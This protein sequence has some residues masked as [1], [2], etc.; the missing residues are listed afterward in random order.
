MIL[1]KTNLAD[2][3]RLVTLALRGDHIKD[4]NVIYTKA[5]YVKVT[6]EDDVLI[7]LDGELGGKT[8]VELKT[9]IDILIFLLQLTSC[10]KRI[11]LI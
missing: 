11:V 9:Y 7:N 2:F 5:N 10:E 4:P 1:K 3:V 8:P 6:I